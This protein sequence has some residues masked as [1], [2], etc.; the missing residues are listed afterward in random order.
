MDTNGDKAVT[1]DEVTA[2]VN[3]WK[4]MRTAMTSVHCRVTLDGEPL[5]GAKIVFEPEAFLGDDIK[6]AVGETNVYGDA[7]PAVP[8][9][10]RGAPNLPGGAH[11][12][13]YKVRI[14]KI[15]NGKE[16]VPARYNSQT[17]L[18]QEVSYDDPAIKNRSM[19]FALKSGE[20]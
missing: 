1:A 13:L 20:K 3:A 8:P 6:A 19:I 18:G 10:Q 14:S 16:T 7:A 12:G 11:L 15:V 9:E 17:I 4:E 5:A 2:R